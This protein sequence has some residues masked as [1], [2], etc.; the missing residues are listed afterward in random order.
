V[1]SHIFRHVAA[2]VTKLA[3]RYQIKLV[4]ITELKLVPIVGLFDYG[5]RF[6]HVTYLSDSSD[7][8]AVTP[9]S[10][11]KDKGENSFFAHHVMK[12]LLY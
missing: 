4:C 5:G 3:T 7:Q 2:L 6:Y 1:L 10:E 11:T 8:L 12:Q 9:L